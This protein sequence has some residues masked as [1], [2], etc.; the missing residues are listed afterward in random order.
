MLDVLVEL[1]QGVAVGGYGE[2]VGVRNPYARSAGCVLG[3]DVY[4]SRRLT[5]EPSERGSVFW[6]HGEHQ[7]GLLDHGL[8]HRPGAVGLGVDSRLLE[9]RE[10]VLGHGLALQRRGPR[11]LRP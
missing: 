4:A 9:R 3:Q 11:A 5:A 8:A 7:L 2:P 6:G 1:A 10:G